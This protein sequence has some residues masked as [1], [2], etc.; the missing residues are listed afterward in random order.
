[1][2]QLR[3]YSTSVLNDLRQRMGMP[4]QDLTTNDVNDFGRSNR[5]M[6]DALRAHWPEYLMEALEL[7]LFMVAACAFSV[8]LFHPASPVPQVIPNE[9]IGR[10]ITN[11]SRDGLNRHHHHLLAT[12]QT[13]RRTLQSSRNADVPAPRQDRTWDAVFYT[14]FQFV[15]GIAGVL[16]ASLSVG[17]LVAHH[18]VNYVVTVPGRVVHGPPLSPN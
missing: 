2:E 8:L 10:R 6:I 13:L 11:G 18:A 15:G 12:R 16:L 17:E 1:M 4:A 7:G 3:S 14:L 5:E 9:V